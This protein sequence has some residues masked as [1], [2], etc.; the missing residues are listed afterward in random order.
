MNQLTDIEYLTRLFTRH[1]FH[2]SKGLGQNFIVDPTVCPRIAGSAGIDGQGVLEIGPGAG[3]LTRALAE[4]AGK[5]VSLEVDRR[6]E[7]LLKETLADCDN[8]T[9][10]F[11]D[12]MTCDLRQLLKDEFG[13]Q[14]VSVCANL[15][16]Y[17]TSPLLLRLLEAELNVCAM[18]LM[19]QKEAA[20]RLCAPMGTRACGPV[21]AAVRFYAEPEILFEVSRTS[22]LPAPTV[23]SAV[24]R[25]TLREPLLPAEEKDAFFR[26]VKAA[27]AL[28]RKTLLN[29]L[30][31]SL[32]LPK[33]RVTAALEGVGVAPTARAETLTME[34]LVA[35]TRQI[36]EEDHAL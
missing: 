25:L 36:Q 29:S 2:L 5:V 9:V 4:R 32:P 17:I 7:P 35:L 27:F 18:T 31:A 34:Q 16:Y 23:D 20:V 26:V 14:P 12:A 11:E 30:S 1:G 10:R 28:R 21:T 24:I 33:D 13:E 15:P 22:F 19:V 6:L 3:V 8:V